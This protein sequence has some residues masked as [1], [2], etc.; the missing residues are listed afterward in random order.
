[1]AIAQVTIKLNPFELQIV[2]DALMVYGAKMKNLAR[3]DLEQ[4]QVT[5]PVYDGDPRRCAVAAEK[6]RQDIGLKDA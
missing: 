3:K 6:I 2:T 4:I 1:M 5:V